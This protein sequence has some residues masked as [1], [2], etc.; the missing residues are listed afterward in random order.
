MRRF[1]SLIAFVALL[2]LAG[3]C[4][5]DNPA[6]GKQ[7]AASTTV[8]VEGDDGVKEVTLRYQIYLPK[9]YDTKT[10]E[11]WPLMLFLHGS[12]ERGDDLEKVKIHG[13]PKLA[14]QGKE[15]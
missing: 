2:A 5:A 11:K 13:P 10:T 1:T 12:G 15:F 6:A 3:F 7:V 9:E 14:G 8:K 4:R